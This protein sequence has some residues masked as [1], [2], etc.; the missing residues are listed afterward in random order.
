MQGAATFLRRFFGSGNG[1]KYQLIEN[2]VH[3]HSILHV[4][5]HLNAVVCAHVQFTKV[6]VPKL[7]G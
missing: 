4:R 7:E 1:I 6:H 5:F 3:G 2:G